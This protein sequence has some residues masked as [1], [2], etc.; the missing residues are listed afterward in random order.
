MGRIVL[1]LTCLLASTA[2]AGQWPKAFDQLF[3]AD[4]ATRV[5]AANELAKKKP[6]E[7]YPLLEMRKWPCVVDSDALEAESQ[8][9]RCRN[10]H[11]VMYHLA[12]VAVVL[13]RA[14][15]DLTVP[16]AKR[17]PN[18]CQAKFF[19]FTLANKGFGTG[20]P[21]IPDSP[22]SLDEVAAHARALLEKVLV[23]AETL[24]FEQVVASAHRSRATNA[25]TDWLIVTN[26]TEGGISEACGF[27]HYVFDAKSHQPRFTQAVAMGAPDAYGIHLEGDD[28]GPTP[29]WW[30]AADG[31]SDVV[32]VY[33][34]GGCCGSTAQHVTVYRLE[35]NALRLVCLAE[36]EAG[37]LDLRHTFAKRIKVEADGRCRSAEPTLKLRPAP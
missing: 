13:A 6:A 14:E 24:S 21:E 5:R 36:D 1:V 17:C 12:S 26:C 7:L 30:P 10:L 23:P 8:T 28:E 15:S 4:N 31:P 37:T 25:T 32:A 35:K 20:L 11:H 16:R 9:G 22:L 29:L 19:L 2:F 3:S 18:G 33:A 34:A 27:R